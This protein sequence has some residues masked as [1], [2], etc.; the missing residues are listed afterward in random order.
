MKTQV[1]TGR[2][3]KLS[4][5]VQDSHLYQKGVKVLQK[6]KLCRQSHSVIRVIQCAPIGPELQM[7]L[8]ISRKGLGIVILI[9]TFIELRKP[10]QSEKS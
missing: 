4:R 3:A 6:T 2:L 1:K 10:Y 7:I 5:Q 8:Y 9:I